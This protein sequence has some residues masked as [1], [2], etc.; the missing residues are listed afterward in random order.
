MASLTTSRD[1]TQS[2]YPGVFSAV[3]MEVTLLQK[4]RMTS[5]LNKRQNVSTVTAV[6]LRENWQAA[7]FTAL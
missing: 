5:V 2:V 1:L 4:L 3:A 7:A 6:Q